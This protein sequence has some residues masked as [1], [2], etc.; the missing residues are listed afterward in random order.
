MRLC[1]SVQN[2]TA[3]QISKY[4]ETKFVNRNAKYLIK[5]YILSIFQ[6]NTIIQTKIIKICVSFHGDLFNTK[7]CLFLKPTAFSSVYATIALY[8]L[9]SKDIQYLAHHKGIADTDVDKSCPRPCC[10][11][12]SI[13]ADSTLDGILFGNPVSLPHTRNADVVNHNLLL[14]NTKDYKME[15]A[16]KQP[17]LQDKMERD[18]DKGSRSHH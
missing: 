9:H 16:T 6:S 1:A 10:Y 15:M 3:D 14:F 2:N 13:N 4:T 7:L 8:D 11:I 18:C 5:C 17:V 12:T